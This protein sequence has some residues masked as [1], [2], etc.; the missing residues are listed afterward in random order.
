MESNQDL[1]SKASSKPQGP[2]Q[3]SCPHCRRTFVP[4]SRE[5]RELQSAGRLHQQC[6]GCGKALIVTRGPDGVLDVIS[7]YMRAADAP[8]SPLR[9][10]DPAESAP[11]S[12]RQSLVDPPVLQ[13]R[14]PFRTTGRGPVIVA[15]PS[16]Q[17]VE[18]S[19]KS[20]KAVQ[21]IIAACD[22]LE[23]LSEKWEAAASRLFEQV[24]SS[25]VAELDEL[26]ERIKDWQEG[27]GLTRFPEPG[28]AFDA[29]RH[30]VDS[31]VETDDM[32]KV[33]SIKEV[34][35][36]GYRLGNDGPVLRRALVVRWV[37]PREQEGLG[38]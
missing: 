36:S 4:T 2:T 27:A 21:E 28:E 6:K 11:G 22:R 31:V 29:A 7:D 25:F 35:R 38:T 37:K 33:D 13:S 14:R 15:K 24:K 34:V 10:P 26:H 23:R 1:P 18:F 32:A 12:G 17:E 20:Y 8:Q 30:D 3:S 19:E 5:E 16:E 9:R